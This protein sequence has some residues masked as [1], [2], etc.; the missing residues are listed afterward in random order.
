MPRIGPYMQI[1]FRQVRLARGVRH[2][3]PT[4]GKAYRTSA[5]TTPP[6]TP[7]TTA[8]TGATHVV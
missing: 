3:A 7:P 1:T 6:T 4:G 8:A 5:P 2:R